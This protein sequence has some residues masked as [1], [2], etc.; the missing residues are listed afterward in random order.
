MIIQALRTAVRRQE[1]GPQTVSLGQPFA[2]FTIGA[3]L[4][5]L[6][7]TVAILVGSFFGYQEPR[8]ASSI[9]SYDGS[10]LDPLENSRLTIETIVLIVQFV[11]FIAIV[12]GLLLFNAALSPGGGNSLGAGFTFIISGAL[13]VNFPGF[14]GVMSELFLP[15]E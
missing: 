6:P 10:V 12:R 1:F 7:Y 9:F 15:S 5:A 14:F 8:D 13:A 2:Q 3:C 4:L 11:G